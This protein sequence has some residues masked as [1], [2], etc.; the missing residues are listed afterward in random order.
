MSTEKPRPAKVLT[1]VPG[2][3]TKM[4]IVL[5]RLIHRGGEKSGDPEP[6]AGLSYDAKGLFT[7]FEHIGTACALNMY[8]DE[9]G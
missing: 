2:S 1:R 8:I 7:A 6:C 3:L 4:K 9:T 5:A